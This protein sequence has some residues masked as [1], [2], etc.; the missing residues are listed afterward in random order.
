MLN[1]HDFEKTEVYQFLE[2]LKTYAYG[3]LEL[4]HA[5]AENAEQAENVSPQ[6]HITHSLQS[7]MKQP[8]SND[9]IIPEFTNSGTSSSTTTLKSTAY[10]KGSMFAPVP[11]SQSFRATIPFTMMIL[12]CMEMVGYL[13]RKNGV[14]GQTAKNIKVFF[15]HVPVNIKK[16]DID[17]LVNVFRHGLAH[18]YF[19][20]LGHAVS[21][22]SKN[23]QNNLFYFPTDGAKK[24]LDVNFLEIASRIGLDGISRDPA[25]YE[26]MD[27]QY[28]RLIQS[29]ETGPSY[30]PRKITIR[31]PEFMVR[32]GRKV[33]FKV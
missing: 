15:S 9:G 17:F 7:S 2:S 18:N 23:P 28:R 1:Q 5:L 20:K 12:T 21:Y 27:L 25:L 11:T 26:T 14:A 24:T 10:S 6:A 8:D 33:G 22:H 19:P 16:A 31:V 32:L 3:D 13:V 29:Y 30:R 4:F